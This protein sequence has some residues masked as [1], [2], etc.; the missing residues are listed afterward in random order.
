MNFEAL[1]QNLGFPIVMVIMIFNFMQTTVK[2]MTKALE[3]NTQ[4]TTKLYEHI[5][6]MGGMHDE[7]N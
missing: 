5:S 2:D 3:N 6:T 4:I 7:R 1:I